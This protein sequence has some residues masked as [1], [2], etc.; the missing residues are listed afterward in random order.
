V[1]NRSRLGVDLRIRRRLA[2][3]FFGPSRERVEQLL[4]TSPAAVRAGCRHF[5][6]LPAE[7][8]ELLDVG[9]RTAGVLFHSVLRRS[10]SKALSGTRS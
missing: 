8:R 9:W 1:V 6:A 2:R 3:T 5:G 4:V 7:N 10:I